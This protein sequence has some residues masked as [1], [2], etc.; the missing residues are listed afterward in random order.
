MPYPGAINVVELIDDTIDDRSFVDD[1][2]LYTLCL[3]ESIIITPPA[4]PY[5]F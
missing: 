4:P 1:A 2:T 5:T 3:D